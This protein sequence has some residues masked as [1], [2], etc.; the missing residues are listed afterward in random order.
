[1]TTLISVIV[2]AFVA[3]SII[4]VRLRAAKK[5]TSLKKIIL[6]PI[7]MCTGFSMFLDPAI[8]VHTYYAVESLITGMV[9]SIPLILT[10]K[11]EVREGEVFLKR[12]KSFVFILL[13]LFLIRTLIKIYMG[14]TISY[15]E[16]GALFYILAVGMIFPWRIAM[17]VRF[18]QLTKGLF[19]QS[20]ASE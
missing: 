17:M 18:Q 4:V 11:F 2:T 15:T 7:F 16:S 8:Q 20:T 1:L 12:S 19:K 6:P 5:P 14:G 3:M 10:S 13:G 9:F